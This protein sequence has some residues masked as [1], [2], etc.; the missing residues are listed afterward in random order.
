MHCLATSYPAQAAVARDAYEKGLH[1]LQELGDM[2]S[3]ANQQAFELINRRMNE[4][5]A[6]AGEAGFGP[7]EVARAVAPE[8]VVIPVASTGRP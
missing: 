3:G 8:D 4:I 2:M 6:E 5:V 7:E 1:N